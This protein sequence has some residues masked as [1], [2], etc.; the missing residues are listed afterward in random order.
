[1]FRAVSFRSQLDVTEHFALVLGDIA[2]AD[3]GPGGILV[4]VHSECQTGGRVRLEALQLRRPA[5]AGDRP[6]R[7]QG[8]RSDR[9]PAGHEGRGIGLG[10]PVDSREYGIGAAILADLGVH[11]IRLITNNPYK[12]GGLSG[13]DL[14]LLGRVRIPPLSPRTT[15]PICGPNATGW[16]MTYTSSVW[17]RV[18]RQPALTESG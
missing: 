11:R 8:R 14:Q 15:G 4:R 18:L 9:L 2:A 17:K 5:A 13:Y 3:S 1:V 16:G 10:L 6:D 12:Y 7:R